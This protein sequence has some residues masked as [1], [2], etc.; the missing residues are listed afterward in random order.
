ML[1]LYPHAV[2]SVRTQKVAP[3]PFQPR[4]KRLKSPVVSNEELEIHSSSKQEFWA[5]FRLERQTLEPSRRQM[6]SKS[7]TKPKKW[8]QSCRRDQLKKKL[9]PVSL[10]KT[11]SIEEYGWM[12]MYN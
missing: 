10:M 1:K 6:T 4:Q 7:A 5:I 9:Y 12:N 8:R 3:R 11:E 2:F